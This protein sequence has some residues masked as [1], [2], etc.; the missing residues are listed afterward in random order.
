VPGVQGHRYRGDS[1]YQT[2]EPQGKRVFGDV[3][4]L[5]AYH[6]GLYLHG[7]RNAEAG[8]N[9]SSEF[10][11]TENGVGIMPLLRN[12]GRSGHRLKVKKTKVLH[13][14]MEFIY[15]AFIANVQENIDVF[16]I[17]CF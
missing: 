3:I 15:S 10:G 8:R 12:R 17:L 11:D 13:F 7:Q 4:D 16:Y 1:F 6:Y 2:N 5:P 14:S 9:E